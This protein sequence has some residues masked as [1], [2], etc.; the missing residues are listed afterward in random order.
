[1]PDGWQR[2]TLSPE[3]KNL[4]Q[5]KLLDTFNL[6]LLRLAFLGDD[7]LSIDPYQITDGI[8]KRLQEGAA[9]ADGTVDANVALTATSLNKDNFLTTML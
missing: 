7:A 1:M 6:N 4:M 5:D 2:G 9:A 8:Y 3:V